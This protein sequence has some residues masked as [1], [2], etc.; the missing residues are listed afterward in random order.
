MFCHIV[1]L[2][3]FCVKKAQ[4]HSFMHSFFQPLINLFIKYLLFDIIRQVLPEDEEWIKHSLCF[5]GLRTQSDEE[6]R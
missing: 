1:G 2:C 3:G 6:G 5:Y 4:F